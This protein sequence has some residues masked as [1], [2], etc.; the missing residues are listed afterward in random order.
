MMRA[1][2][3]GAAHRAVSG[4]VRMI[5]SSYASALEC[6]WGFDVTAGISVGFSRRGLPRGK[7]AV[8][9]LSGFGAACG[10]RMPLFPADFYS[11][12]AGLVVL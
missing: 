6:A 8:E 7:T 2:R 1:A 4:S 9:C 12:C 10:Y 3:S 5:F 11:K